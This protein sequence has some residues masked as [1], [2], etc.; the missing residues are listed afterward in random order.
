MC[1]KS[2][3]RNAYSL[4][5]SSSRFWVKQGRQQDPDDVREVPFP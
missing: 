4:R 3:S 5:V 1:G 2:P